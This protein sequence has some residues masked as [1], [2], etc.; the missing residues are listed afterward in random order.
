MLRL[1]LILPERDDLVASP[2]PAAKD[3]DMLATAG[4]WQISNELA[5][6]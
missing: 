3:I 4:A 2:T 6:D 1:R 5:V